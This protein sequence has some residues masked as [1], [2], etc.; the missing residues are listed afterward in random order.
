MTTPTHPPPLDYEEAPPYPEAPPSSFDQAFEQVIGLEGGY[1][2]D[3]D[4][5]GGETN[6][7]VSKRSYPEVDIKALT[8]NKAKAIYNADYWNR[9]RLP[10]VQ[11]RE[12]AAEVFEQGVN[13]GTSTA[14]TH[15]QKSLNL[16]G[17][18]VAVDGVIGPQTLSAVNN[19]SPEQKESLLKCLNGFQFGYYAE[20]AGNSPSQKKFFV[21]W[22]KR[23]G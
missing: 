17:E 12:I 7:G 21:G 14:I 1:S 13:L 10:D 20:I 16:V 5:Y 4:D 3:I 23:I 19:L 18:P 22:L 15:L 8:K 2:F 6:W 11:D 9:M